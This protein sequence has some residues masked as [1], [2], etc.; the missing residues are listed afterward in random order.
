MGL[1]IIPCGLC[2]TDPSVCQ[3]TRGFPHSS[4][5]E[6]LRV[7]LQIWLRT[8]QGFF[9][10]RTVFISQLINKFTTCTFVKCVLNAGMP[11]SPAF[12]Q[13]GTGMNKNADA[14]TGPVLG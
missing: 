7:N 4:F 14:V 6:F 11:D 10:R 12:G 1:F 13:S 9:R 8:I 2:E 5:P 3:K